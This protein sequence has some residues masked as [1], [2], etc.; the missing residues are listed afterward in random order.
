MRIGNVTYRGGPFWTWAW[1][2]CFS[3]N[4]AG[5]VVEGR[6]ALF[7]GGGASALAFWSKWVESLVVALGAGRSA[8]ARHKM[9]PIIFRLG[10]GRHSAQFTLSSTPV[11]WV[12]LSLHW[13]DKKRA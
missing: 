12:L 3:R 9:R 11:L 8:T 5:M 13:V 10:Q 4:F 2:C 7:F 6:K 1:S